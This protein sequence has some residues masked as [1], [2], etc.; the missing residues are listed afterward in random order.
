MLGP[1][2]IRRV[3]GC[4]VL[5]AVLGLPFVARSREAQSAGS[6]IVQFSP[7][8]RPVAWNAS[9]FSVD[10]VV[11]DFISTVMC[12]TDPQDPNSPMAPCGLGAFFFEVRWDPSAL[13]YVGVLPG[14]FLGSTGRGLY[15]EKDEDSV[16]SGTVSL[17][18]VSLGQTPLGPEGSGVLGTVTFRPL[19]GVLGGSTGLTMARSTLA[20]AD[21]NATARAHE[22][23]DGIVNYVKCAEVTGRPPIDLSD[24]LLTLGHFGEQPSSPGWDPRFDFVADGRVDL[25]DVLFVVAL[26]GQSCSP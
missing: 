9:S 11:T 10:V 8:P 26:Y 18:C 25:S 23:R 2:W 4:L 17:Y 21:P 7:D 5:A 16:A 24:I 1:C 22:R 13:A 12:L 14:P 15:C 3:C 20:H 6:P 19:S